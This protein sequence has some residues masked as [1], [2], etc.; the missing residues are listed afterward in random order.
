MLGANPLASNGSLMTAPDMRG[1]LRA[2]RARGGKLVVVDPRR[3]RTAEAAD[4]HHPI[5]PGTD[6]LLLFALVHVLFDEGLARARAARRARPTA[7]TTVARARR[8][9]SRPR[10]SRRVTGIAADDDPP[11][12]ARARRRR[13]GRGLRPDRH[14][15]AG[16]RHA[17]LL[18]RRRAQR[19]DRQPRP[20]GRRDVPARRRRPAQLRPARPAA[21]AASTLGRW[22]SRVRGLPESVRRA[23]GRRARR[24]DRDAR[25]GPGPRADH[26]RRQPGA[27]DAELRRASSAR[28]ARLDFCVASTSTSTRR[29]A[30]PT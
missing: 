23:A 6:A 11:H 12:G 22:H 19:A 30:T 26:A 17:R 16:V 14:D 13:V 4:E 21:A 1:R 27:L 3:S 2:L 8:S 24:G 20:P 5:R 29:R 15:D 9:R 25:R 7:S 28:S 18:A 10:R